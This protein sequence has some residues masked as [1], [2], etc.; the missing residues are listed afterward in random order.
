MNIMP[1]IARTL[2]SLCMAIALMLCLCV[3]SAPNAMAQTKPVDN[4]ERSMCSDGKDFAIEEPTKEN[5]GI[6]TSIVSSIEETLNTVSQQVFTSI[7]QNSGFSQVVRG[8]LTLFILVYGI[9]FMTGMVELKFYDFVTRMIKF[10]IVAFL[11]KPDAW[12]FF[13]DTV[14]V[15]FNNGTNDIIHHVTAFTLGTKYQPGAGVFLALDGAIAKAASGKMAVAVLATFATGPYGVLFGILLLLSLWSFLK[16]LLTAMWIYIMSLAMKTLLFGLAPIFI[17][18]IL[19]QRT[20]HL[21]K[22]WLDQLVNAS[23]QPILLFMFFAFFI[24]L[25]SQSMVNIL[26]APVCWTELPQGWRGSQFTLYYWRFAMPKFGPDGKTALLDSAGKTIYEPYPGEWTWDQPFPIDLMTLLTFLILAELASRFN[27][28]VVQ[29]ASEIAGAG[30][31][32]AGMQGAFSEMFGGAGG[33]MGGKAG[34]GLMN[35]LG[36]GNKGAAAKEAAAAAAS[37]RRPPPA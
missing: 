9:L 27:S 10:G 35:V 31:S 25:I 6:I 32:M 16:S 20:Q 7:A 34:G 21:F 19:F 15:F 24:Q 13:S 5:P 2:P 14:I 17:P 29:I 23:L 12:T 8:A 3:F 33:G 26:H 36:G 28:V 37:V 18:C 4:K 11:L 30:T 1:P 22:G